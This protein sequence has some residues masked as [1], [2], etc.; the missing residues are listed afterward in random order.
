MFNLFGRKKSYR[1]KE[2]EST[3][4]FVCSH[5]LSKQSPILYASHDPEGDWQFL[6]GADDHASGDANLISLGQAAALDPTLNDLYEM[7]HGVG[8]QR[9]TVT[10]SWSPFRL[11]S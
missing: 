2:A 1:F 4:C 8:A 11:Q 5:V 10:G 3:A 7:P 6:C 9:S